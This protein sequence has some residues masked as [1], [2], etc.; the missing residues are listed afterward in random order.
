MDKDLKDAHNKAR[1]LEVE[2]KE[3]WRESASEAQASL[4]LKSILCRL[5]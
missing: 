5:W 3:T 1:N 2:L 4:L